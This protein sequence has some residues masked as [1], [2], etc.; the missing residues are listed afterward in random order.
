[1]DALPSQNEPTARGLRVLTADENRAALQRTASLLEELGHEVTACAASVS[2]ACALILRDEPDVAVVV[3][4]DDIG[5]ALDLIEE[6]AEAATGPVIAVLDEADRE[7]AEAAA[8][9]GLS[10]LADEQTTESLQAAI[11]VAVRRHADTLRLCEQVDQLEHALARRAVIERAK[12]MLMERH[13]IGE[14][15]A[16]EVM[17]RHARSRST[18]VVGVAGEVVE[19]LD[20]APDPRALSD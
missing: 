17:R 16:F 1:M 3:V 9:R 11:E 12:G 19:G 2:E 4:H 18:T 6:L 20:L 10:A 13:G 15:E 8:E 14:R 5:H 7:F